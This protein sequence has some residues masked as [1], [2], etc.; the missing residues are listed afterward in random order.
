LV[1]VAEVLEVAV[2]AE[3]DQLEVVLMRVKALS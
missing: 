1:A 3:E 2:A